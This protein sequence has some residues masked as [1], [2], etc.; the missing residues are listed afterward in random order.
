MP[1][2]DDDRE[3]LDDREFPEPDSNDNGFAETV[4]CPSCRAQVYEEAE[5]CPRCGTY[6]LREDLPGRRP[7]WFVIAALL[8]LIVALAWA[9]WG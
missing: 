8:C 9:V 3:D 6:I 7:W 2:R 4:P 5:R 1:F